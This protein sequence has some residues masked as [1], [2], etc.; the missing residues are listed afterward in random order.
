MA[1]SSMTGE[2]SARARQGRGL[3][4]LAFAYFALF[5]ILILLGIAIA[6]FGNP[7]AGEPIV[8]FTLAEGP[9]TVATT[10]LHPAGTGAVTNPAGPPGTPAAKPG[11]PTPP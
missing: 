11:E 1:A 6:L 9:S 5:A 8:R 10:P 7:E 4:L 3:R 2:D